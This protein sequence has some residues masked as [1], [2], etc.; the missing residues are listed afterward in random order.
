MILRSVLSQLSINGIFDPH[1]RN[2]YQLLHSCQRNALLF[3]KLSHLRLSM[4]GLH[5]AYV[6]MNAARRAPTDHEA[7]SRVHGQSIAARLVESMSVVGAGRSQ[8]RPR[9]P[10]ASV[11][12]MQNT[13]P[14]PKD[15]GHI[16]Q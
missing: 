10:P 1:R 15:S 11:G 16:T 6:P 9:N 5:S 2:T 4:I 14:I 8:R 3:C 7:Y 13:A 12:E